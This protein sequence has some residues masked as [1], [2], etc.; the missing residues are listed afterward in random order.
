[1]EIKAPLSTSPIPAMAGQTFPWRLKIE[2]GSRHLDDIDFN[3][4]ILAS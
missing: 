1:M 3:G 4:L 2:G